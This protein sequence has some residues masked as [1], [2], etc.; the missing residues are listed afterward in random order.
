MHR[1]HGLGAAAHSRGRIRQT[2]AGTD[3]APVAAQGGCAEAGGTGIELAWSGCCGAQEGWECCRSDG[4]ERRQDAGGRRARRAADRRGRAPRTGCSGRGACGGGHGTR[5]C[6]VCCATARRQAHQEPKAQAPGVF[7]TCLGPSTA[8]HLCVKFAA[9]FRLPDCKGAMMCCRT[10]LLMTSRWRPQRKG[11]HSRRLAF[12]MRWWTAQTDEKPSDPPPTQRS[13]RCAGLS[14]QPTRFVAHPAESA[15]YGTS[16]AVCVVLRSSL[17]CRTT[18][19]CLPSRRTVL[20]SQVRC[21]LAGPN[22]I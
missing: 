15:I 22:C 1:P 9:G 18:G 14:P 21:L 7:M 10:H 4:A 20:T 19:G 16:A 2:V 8:Q 3:G 5:S 6:T 11:L 13:L 12:R 17:L